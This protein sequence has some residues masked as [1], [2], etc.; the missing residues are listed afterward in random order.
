MR[1]ILLIMFLVLTSYPVFA[2]PTPFILNSI[3]FPD[4]GTFPT[5]YTC[6]G[7]DISPE[8]NWINV[9][10]KTKSFV[11]ILSDP[12]APNGTFYHWVVYNLPKNIDTLSE[13]IKSLPKGA[14]LGKNDWGKQQYNGP[15]PPKG[16]AHN[17]KFTI[18]ALDTLLNL[19]ANTDA[20]TV[21][22]AIQ[23]HIMGED[24]ITAVYARW[25]N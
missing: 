4:Q 13:D 24:D 25:M 10:L 2:N 16:D 7:K 5:L 12:N 14:K 11:L 17:Y 3:S 18:Y 20:K 19:P 8:L 9:P 6:D 15:C 21:L 1:H 23:G 22:S